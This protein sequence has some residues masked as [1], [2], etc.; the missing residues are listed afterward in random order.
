[1]ADT[2]NQSKPNIGHSKSLPRPDL[3][4]PGRLRIGHLMTLYGLSHSTFYEHRKR[5]L[6]PPPDGSVAGRPY[7]R[8]ETIKADLEK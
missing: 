1:M 4:A 8:T 7:W 2:V 3:N 6:L 5:L